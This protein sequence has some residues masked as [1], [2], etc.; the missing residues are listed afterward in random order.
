MPNTP[1]PTREEPSF[2]DRYIDRLS[3]AD[4]AEIERELKWLGFNDD[5]S[6]TEKELHEPQ[7]TDVQSKDVLYDPKL[8][9]DADIAAFREII[10]RSASQVDKK[11]VTEGTKQEEVP[12]LA[13][14]LD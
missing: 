9:S 13:H 14:S 12:E 4:E 3:T 7:E 2:I 6:K 10:E 11:P 1:G 5:D 8:F